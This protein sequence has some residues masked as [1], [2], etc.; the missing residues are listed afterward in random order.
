MKYLSG[1]LEQYYTALT[2]ELEID[3]TLELTPELLENILGEEFIDGT[4]TLYLQA[5]DE[6]NLASDIIE[7][8]FTFS[9]IDLPGPEVLSLAAIYGLD[10][11]P[12]AITLPN[13]GT[14]QLSVTV[15]GLVDSPELTIDIGDISY[16]VA[17]ENVLSVSDEGLVTATGVG[18]TTV[19]V[20]YGEASA[21]IPVL[22]DEPEMGAATVDENGGVVEGSDGSLVML[23]PGA[24]TEETSVNITPLQQQDLSLPVPEGFEFA[25]AFNLEI[26][27]DKL[28]IPAQ[29][30]IPA[31]EGIETGTEVFFLRK[32]ALPDETGTWNDI[33]L[34]EES[35][36]VDADGFIR[37][38]SPPYPGVVRPG[39]YMVMSGQGGSAT[40]P[41]RSANS[42][43]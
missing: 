25:T 1:W 28:D 11:Y 27:D 12:D 41:Q 5:I 35:G 10:T 6:H 37:T 21:T 29:L 30:A 17:D 16:T 9:E 36:V 13:T 33:W 43:N 4:Y 18:E 3:G 14:R 22:V 19:T 34:Q 38:T 26:E 8:E 32:G 7:F 15:D 23:A 24:L 20:E 42:D 40:K 2:I 39:E 31:P